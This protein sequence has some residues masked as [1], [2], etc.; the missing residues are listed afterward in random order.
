MKICHSCLKLCHEFRKS[1]G[2]ASSILT[3]AN[4]LQ[5]YPA[6]KKSMQAAIR[7][8]SSF[9]SMSRCNIVR[10]LV[11]SG[12]DPSRDKIAFTVSKQ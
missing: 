12:P 4:S 1:E 8:Q 3:L 5:L 10:S 7:V 2:V 11:L 6:N 9:L